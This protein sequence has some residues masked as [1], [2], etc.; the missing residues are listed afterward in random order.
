ML[1]NVWNA[2]S[3]LDTTGNVGLFL[4]TLPSPSDDAIL[5]LHGQFSVYS[6]LIS[7]DSPAGESRY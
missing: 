4:E 7:Q 2:W 1:A 5:G 3:L 6:D